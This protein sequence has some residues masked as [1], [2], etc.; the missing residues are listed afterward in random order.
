MDSSIKNINSYN[1]INGDV[2]Q[3]LNKPYQPIFVQEDNVN[4]ISE[5][6]I[7]NKVAKKL[8]KKIIDSAISKV[9]IS[10]IS[11]NQLQPIKPNTEPKSNES[12]LKKRVVRFKE[13]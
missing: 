2:I 11:Q 10:A 7:I 13:S 12:P 9:F 3:P 6:K 1:C 5:Q 8:G 4:K